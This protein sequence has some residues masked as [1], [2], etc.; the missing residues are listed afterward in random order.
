MFL[1]DERP[2]PS[3]Y[4]GTANDGKIKKSFGDNYRVKADEGIGGQY[5]WDPGRTNEKDILNRIQSQKITLN[6]RLGKV[7]PESPLNHQLFIGLG[8]FVRHENYD[9]QTGRP[10]TEHK[11][12]DNP[13]FNDIWM[14]AYKISP[15]IPPNKR[16]KNRMP[17]ADNPDPNGYIKQ[18][19]ER[20][21]VDDVEGGPSVATLL[22]D[23][24]LTEVS[25]PAG[26][27]DTSKTS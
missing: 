26:T 7:D 20:Q 16:A 11:P 21:A 27:E 6:P 18:L 24:K 10:L 5:P 15:T 4:I 19:A 17:S 22:S 9:F 14:A 13:D 8:N 12:Q 1:D 3:R 25:P 2:D 23:K